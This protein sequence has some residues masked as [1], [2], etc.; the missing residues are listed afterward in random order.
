MSGRSQ[1]TA[2]TSHERGSATV[3]TAGG[4]AVLCLLTAAGLVLGGVTQVRHRATAAA[5]LAALAAAA[6][7]PYGRPAACGRAAWVA[8]RMRVRLTSCR[9]AGWDALVEVDAPLPGALTRFGDVAA[10]SRAGPAGP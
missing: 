5:D 9:L 2:S 7:T 6:Y 10:R 8:E 4:I 3:W 1:N